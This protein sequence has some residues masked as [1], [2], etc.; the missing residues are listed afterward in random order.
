MTQLQ[1]TPMVKVRSRKSCCLS[2][3]GAYTAAVTV[4]FQ[5]VFQYLLRSVTSVVSYR[6]QKD[7]SKCT[8]THLFNEE[9]QRFFWGRG[10][11]PLF[12]PHPHWGGDTHFTHT[13]PSR[14]LRPLDSTPATS[15]QLAHCLDTDRIKPVDVVRDLDSRLTMQ[16]LIARTARACFLPRDA[17]MLPRS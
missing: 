12:S 3:L 10:H 2:A 5:C 11:C 4:F 14:G 6:H 16:S 7:H 9:I 8:I 13:H 1:L 17:A 15:E